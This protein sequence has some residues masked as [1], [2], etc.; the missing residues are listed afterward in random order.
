MLAQKASKEA[1][2]RHLTLCT[3][4]YDVPCLESLQSPHLPLSSGSAPD[5]LFLGQSYTSFLSKYEEGRGT[6]VTATGCI[7]EGYWIAGKLHGKGRKIL[8]DGSVLIGDY[9]E[10]KLTGKGVSLTR[11][12]SYAG[13]FEQDM[14]HGYGVE[15]DG[16]GLRYE[17]YWKNNKKHGLGKV[18]DRDDRVLVEGEWSEGNKI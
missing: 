3:F 16:S 7:E 17:G 18:I 5:S 14:Q 12:N 13:D 15:R 8:K 9:A 10:H 1:H 4:K 11:R 2:A 6:R